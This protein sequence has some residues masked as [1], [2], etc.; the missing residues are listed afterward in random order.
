[1]TKLSK[2]APNTLTRIQILRSVFTKFP[3]AD[4]FKLLV[5]ATAMI[6][7][8]LLDLIGVALLGLVGTLSVS[9]IQSVPPSGTV[10]NFLTLLRMED[11]SFQSQVALLALT[12]AFALITRT[13]LSVFFTRRTLKF[14]ALRAAQTTSNLVDRLLSTDLSYIQSKPIQE[15][16]YSLTT[17]SSA[18]MLGVFATSINLL[19]DFSLLIVLSIGMLYVNPMV[20][21][22]SIAFFSLV[23]LSMHLMLNVR[24]ERLGVEDARLNIESNSALTEI[25]SSF[26]EL[27]VHGRQKYYIK[28]IT[29]LRT[30][31]ADT[32]VETAFMPN[33][34]KYMVESALI[35]GAII[36]SA[37]Q[38]VTADASR[39]VATLAIFLAAGSRLAPALLRIQ[40]GNIQIRNYLGIS[41][42]TLKLIEELPIQVSRPFESEGKVDYSHANFVPTV[43]IEN[44]DFTYPG[45][46]SSAISVDQL[47]INS[48]QMVAFVGPSGAG[49]TTFLDVILGVLHPQRGKILISGFD[50]ATAVAEWPGAISYVPQETYIADA[51]I[52]ENVALGFPSENIDR[53]Q[54]MENLK[55]AQLW[56]FVQSLELGIEARVGERG[57][58]LSGGQR[59]RLGIARALYTKPKLLILDEATSSLDA[60]TEQAISTSIQSLKGEVTLIVI[61]HRLSTIKEADLI[62]YVEKGE[63]KGS[64]TFEEL[65]EKV[66]NFNSSASIMGL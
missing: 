58:Q 6:F 9:G 3:R 51:T 49:K 50:P 61:A 27:S 63:I 45:A 55:L 37:I 10:A 17:G 64:G 14:F 8:S 57:T 59:Q 33:I 40:Q 53:S 21:L 28:K 18:L 39:A 20:A 12:A 48:G 11:F 23:G 13:V 47:E 2:E 46:N 41:R 22:S 7:L 35:L 38:F 34:S 19:G 1:V 15:T 4:K 5:I 36:I 62:H 60:E 31:L 44:L 42:K 29:K 54:V 52:A 16:I 24:A 30:E 26:R 66:P 43:S 25:I 56:D 65:R 32:Q